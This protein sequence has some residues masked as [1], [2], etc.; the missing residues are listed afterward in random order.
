[1]LILSREI[2]ESVL[3]GDD[4]RVVPI[5]FD[6][7]AEPVGD[8]RVRIGFRA[9][10]DVTILR[11]EVAA[12]NAAPDRPAKGGRPFRKQLPGYTVEVPDVTVGL[13]IVYPSTLT[14]HHHKLSLVHAGAA[15]AMVSFPPT[16]PSREATETIPSATLEIE[17]GKDDSILVGN[18]TI[19]IVDIRRYVKTRPG[20]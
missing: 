15:K 5:R 7:L 8:A 12:R 18:V 13:R 4:I 2:N 20:T 3:V 9:P 1:M 17:C 10:R 19:I 14:V 6:H 16:T 11:E